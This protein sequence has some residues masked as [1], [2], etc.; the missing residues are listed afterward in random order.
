M[1]RMSDIVVI[2]LYI[3]GGGHGSTCCEQ[4][5]CNR[6]VAVCVFELIRHEGEVEWMAKWHFGEC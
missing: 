5:A 6:L 2:Y 4:A 1:M 3:F